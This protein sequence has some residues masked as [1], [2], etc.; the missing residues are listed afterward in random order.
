VDA[1]AA[2][3]RTFDD[4]RT[5]IAACQEVD[6]W[7]QIDGADW[8]LEIGA[9]TEATADL[10]PGPPM[11]LFDHIKDYPPGY[12]VAS[13]TLASH[14][15]VALALGLPVD[16]PKLELVRLAA[17]K[18]RDV[19][20][21]PPVE[22]SSS[23]LF[24]NVLTGDAVDL[25]R[26]PTP[27]FHAHD[28]GRY[29]GTG[30]A[31]IQRDPDSGFINVGTYR[32]QVHDR[33][34]LGLWVSPGQHGRLIFQRYW[35]R[36]EACPVVATFGGDPLT[37]LAGYQKIPWGKSELDYTGGLRE[38]P[39]PIITGRVTGL[40]IPA[41]AEIAIEGEIPPVDDDGQDE[42]PF[43]EWPGYYSGGTRGTGRPQPV[44]RVKA[45]YFRD[46]PIIVNQAP[47]WPGA[48]VM[49]LP[50]SA[51]L[52]WDQ[53]ESMGIQDIA[54]VYSYTSYLDVV[55]IRQ[56]Y[57]GHAKQVGHA[58]LSASSA[59]RNGRY[60][61][62]VDEDIDPTDIKEVLWAMQT[63]VDPY[64]DI[65][66]VD[67]TWSTPLDPRM[68]PDKR[69]SG[70]HTNSRAIFYAVRPWHW[71]DKFPQVSRSERALREQVVAKYRHLLPFP[72]A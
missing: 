23:P 58:V 70:D 67:G 60:I 48:P 3:P 8:D 44:I 32:V 61:V 15:R 40:P 20:P 71:R 54:G 25:W 9:L 22:V 14:K 28:G 34:R 38:R 49:G 56:R 2:P 17:R 45:L 29:I 51:G 69:E 21:I 72:P 59:A 10:V 66:L 43:G 64:T 57:A 39:L 53:L 11:L 33:N 5:F 50:T 16:K 12:R 26:F 24:E 37:F 63:R 19:V 1:V 62:V 65:E 27:R 13:L 42:G 68:P 7:R 6:Q 52:L 36:G 47:M 46:E 4:L 55:A 30:D 35:E 18:I 31:I 41:G